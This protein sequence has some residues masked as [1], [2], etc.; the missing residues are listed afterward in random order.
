MQVLS[1][2]NRQQYFH[3]NFLSAISFNKNKEILKKAQESTSKNTNETIQHKAQKFI[4]RVKKG[5]VSPF[6]AVQIALA[7]TMA[8]LLLSVA[9]SRLITGSKVNKIAG[10][11]KRSTKNQF[12]TALKFFNDWQ[13]KDFIKRFN[14]I[15]KETITDSI[16][17]E[18]AIVQTLVSVVEDVNSKPICE[19]SNKIDQILPFLKKWSPTGLKLEKKKIRFFVEV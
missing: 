6:E 2:I 9:G 1:Q 18:K 7:S 4:N 15:P 10:N 19:G 13:K 12:K 3:R 11:L 17:R 14:Q 5:E 8:V 16:S